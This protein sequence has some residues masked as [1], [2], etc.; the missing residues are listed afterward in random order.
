MR[1]MFRDLARDASLSAVVAGF[2]AVLVGYT[3]SVA[4]VFQAAKALGA[5]P[6]QT[7]SWMWALGLAMGVSC[8][9][10]SLR[11]RLPGR[12]GR[13]QSMIVLVRSEKGL[14]V[15]NGLSTEVRRLFLEFDRRAAVLN[16]EHGLLRLEL[17][18]LE[19][20]SAYLR[21]W[22]DAGRSPAVEADAASGKPVTVRI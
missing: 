4:I 3:S 6:A 16:L 17:R 1:Q 7:A 12:D 8:I 13:G 15:L 14:A 20:F 22:R 19:Q 5:N 21:D 9:G 11:W 18:E 2:V 10:L